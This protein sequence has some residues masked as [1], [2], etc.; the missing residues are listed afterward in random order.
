MTIGNVVQHSFLLNKEMV[1]GF[2]RFLRS[3]LFHNTCAELCLVWQP[4]NLTLFPNGFTYD[5]VDQNIIMS[6][7]RRTTSKK[8]TSD[9]PVLMHSGNL[10]DSFES[11]GTKKITSDEPVLMHSGNLGD[12]SESSGTKKITS[13][14]PV[15][16]HSGNLGDSSEGTGTQN[17]Q[18]DL[19][20]MSAANLIK[21]II[22]RNKDPLIEPLLIA[23]SDKIPKEFSE[24][25]ESEKRAR[26]I[27]ISGLKEAPNDLPP[28]HRQKSLEDD[29]S[30]VLDALKV[31]CRPSEIYRIGKSDPKRPRLVKVVLPARSHWRTALANARLLRDA[32]FPQ[33]FIRK[34]M[35]L[36]ERQRDF[37]LRQMARDRNKALSDTP[38]AAWLCSQIPDTPTS[39]DQF[40][41]VQQTKRYKRRR[42]YHDTYEKGIYRH[43]EL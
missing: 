31:E 36:E 25:I 35:T 8:S 10:G 37:E 14:E 38:Q 23:L 12:S 7:S 6:R 5:G 2:L 22:E 24:S 11:S 33:V 34:S 13:D 3:S 19:E 30:K 20:K 42:P 18:L 39:A 26:S 9:E 27:V 21:A 16:K 29:V 28:S 1:A 17:A 4:L 43:D 41:N 40:L 32:G 15:L